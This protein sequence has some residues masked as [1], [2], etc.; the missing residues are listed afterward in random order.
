MRHNRCEKL[1]AEQLRQQYRKGRRNFTNVDLHGHDLNGLRLSGINLSE[2]KLQNCD[3]S[4][5][6]LHGANFNKAEL[7]GAKFNHAQMGMSFL[8]SLMALPLTW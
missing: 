3:F 8:A 1:T 5:A 4:H 2:A 7:A 6:Q